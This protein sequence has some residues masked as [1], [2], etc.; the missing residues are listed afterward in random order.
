MKSFALYISILVFLLSCNKEENKTFTLNGKIEGDFD[1][2]IYLKYNDHLDSILIENSRFQFKGSV[3]HPT[4][5]FLYPGS[6]NSK[7]QMG[8]AAFML[9]NSNINITLKS[10]SLNYNGSEIKLLDIDSIT[11]SRTQIIQKEFENDLLTS[12]RNE[13]DSIKAVLLF[14]KLNEFVSKHHESELAGKYV[15]ELNSFYGYLDA[16]QLEMLLK[17]MDTA[18]QTKKDLDHI[19]SMI[20][21]KR[22]LGVGNK[23][24]EIEL[25][26][27]QGVNI[28]SGIFRGK[29]VLLEFWASWC[30]PCRRSNPDLLNVYNKFSREKFEILGV[31]IDKDKTAWLKAIDEDN[32]VW[33][34]TIDTLGISKDKFKISTIPYNVLLDEE[35][36]ILAT[37]LKPNELREILETKI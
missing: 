6:P 25:P 30:A 26:N 19:K 8:I 16:I 2:Y 24:P 28:N 4:E 35:G 36:K 1:S 15:A 27:Q 31:S 18:Y 5:S 37:E 14:P 21:Q 9:E 3:S 13:T 29:I 17:K 34:Q 11:G 33:P 10:G 12:F 32:I 22:V 20:S 23:P 7:E